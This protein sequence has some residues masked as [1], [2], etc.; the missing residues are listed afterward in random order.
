M[1]LKPEQL[2]TGD[3]YGCATIVQDDDIPF[4]MS[5]CEQNLHTSHLSHLRPISSKSPMYPNQPRYLHQNPFGCLDRGRKGSAPS[6]E[7]GEGVRLELRGDEVFHYGFVHE[8][9]GKEA[10]L[11]NEVVEF[12][13]VEFWA[14]SCFHLFAQAQEAG[15]AVE[16]ADG[17]A[18]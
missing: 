15:V 7:T 5:P 10:L 12:E 16:V 2:D 6:G 8:V 18:G 1:R 13:G 11:E 9:G 4:E 14:E 17:L 3:R